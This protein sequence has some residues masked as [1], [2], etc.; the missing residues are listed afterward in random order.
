[1]ASKWPISSCTSVDQ[2]TVDDM[3]DMDGMREINDMVE[4]DGRT[5]QA[6]EKRNF[7]THGTETIL[8]LWWWWD[9]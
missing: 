8:N 1:M 4:N 2:C 5:I 7:G 3:G 6:Q 9:G